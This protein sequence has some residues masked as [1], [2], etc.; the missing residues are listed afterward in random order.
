MNYQQAAR[1]MISAH[2][3]GARNR[4]L[5]RAADLRKADDHAA[6]GIWVK[7]A[8]EVATLQAGRLEEI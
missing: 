7:V 6:A 2:Q 8:D 3:S 4:A 1:L 5:Q